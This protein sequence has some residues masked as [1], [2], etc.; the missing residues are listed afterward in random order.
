MT[1]TRAEMT[2]PRRRRPQVLHIGFSKCAST[3]LRSLFRAHPKIHLVFKSGFFTPYLAREMTFAQYQTL[4]S[5]E[6]SK[7]NVESDEHLTLPGI[8]PMLGVRTTVLAEFERVADKIKEFLPDV[9]II[10]VIRNQASLIVSRYSEFL[11]QGGS[12]T[13]EEFAAELIGERKGANEYFQNYYHDI[14]G[15]LEARFPRE[16]LLILMQEAMR[17]DTPQTTATIG[18][19]MSLGDGLVLKRGL[20]SE[21]KS[22]SFAGIAILRWLNRRLVRRPSVG[23]APPTTRVP[24]FVY[25]NVVRLVRALD[26]YL[27]SRFS[28]GPTR[29]L[30]EARRRTIQHQFRCDSLKLQQYFGRDLCMFGYLEEA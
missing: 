19:F 14:I 16:N 1:G 8:H 10:M 4:F 24:Q 27:L 15:I 28:P 5:D 18:Q 22:L 23:G 26:Y 25:Q 17:E 9:R 21:R 6:P 30:T 7:V 11:I 20:R 13:F 3:Y 12:L 29:V 2:A